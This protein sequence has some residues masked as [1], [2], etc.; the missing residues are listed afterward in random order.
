M[1]EID[2]T[3]F[4]TVR[5]L[6]GRQGEHALKFL[7]TLEQIDRKIS[8]AEAKNLLKVSGWTV[9]LL[10]APQAPTGRFAGRALSDSFGKDSTVNLLTCELTKKERHPTG[11]AIS[12]PACGKAAGNRDKIIVPCLKESN[13]SFNLAL[14]GPNVYMG[15]RAEESFI[16]ENGSPDDFDGY[17]CLGSLGVHST[18]RSKTRIWLLNDVVVDEPTW[19][20]KAINNDSH[21]PLLSRIGAIA[22][23][24]ANQAQFA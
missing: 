9:N 14:D 8:G 5:T 18:E 20:T 4:D 2:F 24:V 22:Q 11:M 6:A 10:A 13:I 17:M 1:K 7:S 21:R 16:F 12:V 19:H 15:A 3:G 23:K